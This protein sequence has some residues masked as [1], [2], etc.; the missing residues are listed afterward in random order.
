LTEISFPLG[1]VP[2]RL[3]I[4]PIEDGTY[5]LDATYQGL[6][7]FDRAEDQLRVVQEAGVDV[8]F[9]QDLGGGWTLRFGPLRPADVSAA[10]AAFVR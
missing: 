3:S 4:W 2:D 10:L 7:G 9:V 6:T 5:G 8:S 1:P